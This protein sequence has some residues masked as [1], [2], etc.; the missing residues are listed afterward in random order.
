MKVAK[1]VVEEGF[2]KVRRESQG[3]FGMGDLVWE[4][5]VVD[6]RGFQRLNNAEY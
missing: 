3:A 1:E 2:E 6:E 4:V 5:G